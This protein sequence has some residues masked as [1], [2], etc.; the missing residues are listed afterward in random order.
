LCYVRAV[1]WLSLPSALVAA[2]VTANLVWIGALLAVALLAGRGRFSA[3]PAEV[4]TL[5]RR[6]YL[7]LAAPAFLVSFAAGL[8]R[9][10]IA[11]QVYLHLP[12][13]HAKLTLAL[14]VIGLHHVIGA[15]ARRVAGGDANAGSGMPVLAVAALVFASGAVLLAIA[16]SL[17]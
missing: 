11:P 13:M 10:L 5:A 2:H 9:I 17:P 4:G 12:W 6:V 1:H 3:D 15:R 8:A 14:V 7:T 16:K